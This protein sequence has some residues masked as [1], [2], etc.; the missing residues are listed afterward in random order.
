MDIHTMHTTPVSRPEMIHQFQRYLLLVTGILLLTILLRLVV[1]IDTTVNGNTL[2]VQAITLDTDEN[3]LLNGLTNQETGLRGYI[4]T[5]NPVF[6]QPFYLG[7][8]QYLTSII[9]L[10]TLLK[11]NY[12]QDAGSAFYQM[13]TR[14]DVWYRTFALNQ[15]HQIRVG[16]LTSPRSSSSA[17]RG[18]ELF[19]AFRASLVQL[20]NVTNADLNT[21]FNQQTTINWSFLIFVTLLS[22]LCILLIWYIFVM[23]RRDLS[24]QLTVITGMMQ[25][26][27]AG[28][29]QVRVPGLKHEEMEFVGQNLNSLAET[30]EQQHQIIEDHTQQVDTINGEFRALFNAVNSA[31]LFVSSDGRILTVNRFFLELFDV[32]AKTIIG[33][34]LDDFRAS[35]AALFVDSSSMQEVLDVYGKNEIDTIAI[36]VSQIEPE[37]REMELQSLPVFNTTEKY[38]GRLYL[39]RDVTQ[40]HELERLKRDFVSQVSHELRTPLT[41]IKGFVDLLLEDPDSLNSEQLEFLRIVHENAQRLVAL[42]NDLL[43]LARIES[44]KMTL[45]RS[46]IALNPL[47]EDTLQSFTPSLAGKH[48]SLE[49]SL[50][51]NSPKVFA[52]PERTRQILTNLVSNAHKYTLSKGT[53]RVSTHIEDQQVWIA[54]QDSGIGMT[55]QELAKLFS[56]FFRAKNLLTEDIGGTGLGLSITHALVELHGGIIEVESQPGE[57]STFRFTLPLVTETLVTE[58]LATD[59]RRSIPTLPQP[60]GK[61]RVLVVEDDLDNA[62]LLQQLCE[63]QGYEVLQAHSGQDAVRLALQEMPDLITLDLILPDISGLAALETIKHHPETANIPILLLSIMDREEGGR[64]LGPI[65]YLSKP[66]QK[67]E[68]LMHLQNLLH[69]A[70]ASILVFGNTDNEPWIREYAQKHGYTLITASTS[71]QLLALTRRHHPSLIILDSELPPDGGLAALQTLRSA[72]EQ[73]IREIHVL[74]IASQ[75]ETL[76][77]QWKVLERTGGVQIVGHPYQIEEIIDAVNRLLAVGVR[78]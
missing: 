41:S 34:R 57:G 15:L 1:N 66:F 24:T 67:E 16:N 4:A 63:R 35:W 8:S 54:V 17:L 18:K 65:H 45:E 9:S 21:L 23:F 77:D 26:F 44:G 11:Q 43:D 28:H 36:C 14:A 22:F 27:Q 72:P 25:Q 20:Q 46:A 55:P 75:K 51:R 6:L 59:A 71:T 32:A 60:L 38:L 50:E 70:P 62:Y 73:T 69:K 49:V 33:Q 47:I 3:Q 13:H 5:A 53:V 2:R 29:H 42:V 56:R 64:F 7:R 31:I 39:W 40:E 58:T 52:D 76:S 74:V 48:Q 12:F 37:K 61:K 10:N 30:I 19:D 68:I 78:A